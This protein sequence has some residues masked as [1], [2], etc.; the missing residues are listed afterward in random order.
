MTPEP[1]AP[2]IL[3][4]D[5]ERNEQLLAM[6]LDKVHGALAYSQQIYRELDELVS[7][8]DAVAAASDKVGAGFVRVGLSRAE[9]DASLGRVIIK[10]MSKIATA[11][12]EVNVGAPGEVTWEVVHDLTGK[13]L[14]EKKTIL[15]PASD[16]VTSGVKPLAMNIYRQLV[17]PK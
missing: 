14:L 1:A 8:M 7:A 16:S 11:A 3:S 10:A 13:V 12:I 2:P 17:S 15:F 5:A 9:L 6:V 4:F